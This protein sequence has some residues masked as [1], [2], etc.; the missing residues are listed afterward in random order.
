MLKQFL[1]YFFVGGAVFFGT[2]PFFGPGIIKDKI[3]LSEEKVLEL[4]KSAYTKGDVL[5]RN[6]FKG[7]IE[8][9]VTNE[10]LF[11]EAINLKINESDLLVRNWLIRNMKFLLKRQE[12]TGKEKNNDEKY[13]K[14]ALS[15]GLDKKDLVL[16][17][18][19]YQ[20][21]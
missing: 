9:E 7:L 13:F 3:L 18:Y 6:L 20:V 16:S 17:D 10:I 21:R 12:G 4:K 19:L 15:L 8:E 14:E 11:K 5:D 2:K 1:L